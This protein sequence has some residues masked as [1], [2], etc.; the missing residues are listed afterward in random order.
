MQTQH[1]FYSPVLLKQACDALSLNI[2]ELDE[3]V[4]K[5]N[6]AVYKWVIMETSDYQ[7]IKVLSFHENGCCRLTYATVA[8]DYYSESVITYSGNT[9]NELIRNVMEIL[10][11]QYILGYEQYL[12]EIRTGKAEYN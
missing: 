6:I 3:A 9:I 1:S 12:S 2:L 8:P 7:T 4:I 11:E 10:P 5:E